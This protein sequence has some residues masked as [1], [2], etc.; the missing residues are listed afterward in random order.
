MVA[1]AQESILSHCVA[2]TEA[3]E[4]ESTELTDALDALAADLDEE[5]DD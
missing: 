3:L 5:A 1:K 2:A 4:A